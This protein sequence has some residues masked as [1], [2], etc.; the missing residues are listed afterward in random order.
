MPASRLTYQRR[1]ARRPGRPGGG[2]HT[3]ADMLKR[4]ET[5]CDELVRI[6][7]VLERLRDRRR[8]GPDVSTEDLLELF[9]EERDRLF[10]QLREVDAAI[11]E[12]SRQDGDPLHDAE[13]I[14]FRRRALA[15]TD[16]VDFK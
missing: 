2:G 9:R 11:S 6:D 3:S 13:V 8:I 12:D 1:G 15:S 7:S 16:P 10:A 14:E 4:K 5:L